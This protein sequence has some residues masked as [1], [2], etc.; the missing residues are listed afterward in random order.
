MTPGSEGASGARDTVVVGRVR[1]PH[2]VRG[3]LVVEPLSDVEERFA[4]GADLL[5]ARPARADR[6]LRVTAVRRHRDVLLVTFEGIGNRDEAEEL[7]DA[8]LEVPAATSPRAPEGT[9]Y[10][11]DLVGCECRDARSGVLG[12]VVEVIEDG[13]GWLLRIESPGRQL[14]VPFVSA[15]LRAVDP[16]SERIELDLPEG[17]IEACESTS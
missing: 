4:P 10:Y 7:R 11:H 14:L 5:A 17:L 1:R 8:D 16:G 2:G 6:R 12:R 9:Y 15:Y 3:E 13:G